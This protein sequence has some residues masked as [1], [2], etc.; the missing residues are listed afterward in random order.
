MSISKPS[1]LALPLVVL[2]GG[3]LGG[4]KQQQPPAAGPSGPPPVPVTVV[5]ATQESVPFELRVVGSAMASET[6]QVKSQVAGQIVAV[7]FKEGQNVAKGALLFE[8]DARPYQEALKQAEAALARDRAQL[9]QAEANLARDMAQAR[10]AEADAVRYANLTKEGIISKQQNEQ[11]RTSAEV[12]K[13]SVR[14]AQAAIESARAAVQSDEAA[15]DK[16]KLDLAYCRIQAPI[17]GRTGNLLITPGN[18]VAANGPS[19]LVV[20]NQISPV[21]VTFSVPEQ[22]VG[23]IRRLQAQRPLD[24]AAQVQDAAAPP[25]PGRLTVIDNA[26]DATTGTIPL[27]A[28]FDNKD[29]SLWPG[30]FVNVSLRLE[31]I[32]NATVV[33]SEAVQSGQTGSFAYVVKADQTVEP[34]MVKTGRTFAGKIIIEQG[35]APGEIV[36][37]DGHL[38]LAPGSKIQ[39]VPPVK[40]VG[41]ERS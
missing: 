24:V 35:V 17:A 33:P 7:H 26:V 3:F 31:T 25:V 10:N 20:I 41:V 28:V 4:C 8:I 32:A 36:V 22:H 30:Q 23:V 21:F 6:V 27:K 29:G 40:P 11:V 34:R 37:T 38:R 15:I 16:V 12:F 19:P 39:V 9:R 2:L 1:A 13:E 5:T 14:G 18:L